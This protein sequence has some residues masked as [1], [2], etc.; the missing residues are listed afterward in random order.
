MKHNAFFTAITN[1]YHA[2]KAKGFTIIELMMVVAI[3]GIL[4]VVALPIFQNYTAKAQAAEGQYLLAGLKS[5]LV[6]AVSNDGINAC[7]TD[8]PW[9]TASIRQGQYVNSISLEKNDIQCLMTLTFKNAGVNDKLM[10]KKI[11]MRYTVESAAWECG[12]D[13][14]SELKAASCEAE[15]LNL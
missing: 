14:E 13:L 9:Y 3:L 2:M 7:S 6:E 4:A 1:G 10:G 12:S 15:L 5:P 8:Q 11:T